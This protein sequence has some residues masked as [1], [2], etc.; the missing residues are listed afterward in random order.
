MEISKKNLFRISEAASA[1]GVSRSTLLRMEEAGLLTPAYI[2]SESGRRYY[3]NFSISRVLQVQALKDLGMDV[4]VMSDFFSQSGKI[5]SLLKP[6][7]ARLAELQRAVEELWLRTQDERSCSVQIMTL[8]AVTCRM[9]RCEGHTIAEKY[10]DAYALYTDCVRCGCVL[11]NE[12]L[13]TISDRKDFLE[14][15]IG[16]TP[17]PFYSC[18][19]VRP[20]RRIPDI[21]TLP[22]CRV[23]SVLYCGGY[24]HVDEAWLRL[25]REARERE[26]KI[27]GMPRVLGIVAPYTGR[28]IE[29]KRYCSRIVLPIEGDLDAPDVT[30]G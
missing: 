26:V 20:N 16:T 8:P 18:V 17:Y 1:C 9:S 24:D 15:Y 25:G 30:V 23:L 5:D 7:E 27:V 10:A 13:F 22:R 2:S 12:P 3:D 14:G 4:Q 29:E 28:E 19:P 21:V 6:L 11:T